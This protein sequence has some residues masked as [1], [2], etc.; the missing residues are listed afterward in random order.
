MNYEINVLNLSGRKHTAIVNNERLLTAVEAMQ[1]S[2]R[3]TFI[4]SDIYNNFIY[5]DNVDY[6]VGY[7]VVLQD[8]NESEE[9]LT[10]EPNDENS[11]G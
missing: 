6:V 10:E 2:K 8:N 3:N 9:E 4:I 7:P 5:L 11:V 1:A